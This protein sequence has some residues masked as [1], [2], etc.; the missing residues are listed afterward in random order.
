MYYKYY[1]FS[2]LK[3]L[4]LA[5]ISTLPQSIVR[6]A[7]EISKELTRQKEVGNNYPIELSTVQNHLPARHEDS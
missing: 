7:Q 3:G 4:Q 1:F 5:E 6:E 2:P